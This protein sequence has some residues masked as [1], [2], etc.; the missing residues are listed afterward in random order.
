MP[1]PTIGTIALPRVDQWGNAFVDTYTVL[2][3]DDGREVRVPEPVTETIGLE[4]DVSTASPLGQQ[5]AALARQPEAML[6]GQRARA[7]DAIA[8]AQQTTL[9]PGQSI[10]SQLSALAAAVDGDDPVA[11]RSARRQLEAAVM[12][13]RED[14]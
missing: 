7:A 9:R 3:Y 10:S 8:S 1:D 5:A 12:D 13:A 11:I 2:T 6:R 14:L 4:D